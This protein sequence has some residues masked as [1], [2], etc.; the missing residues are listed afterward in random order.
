MGWK[1]YDL[2]KISDL[3]ITSDTFDPENGYK[4]GDSAMSSIF[5]EL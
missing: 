1:L 4:R 3:V 2:S 5:C